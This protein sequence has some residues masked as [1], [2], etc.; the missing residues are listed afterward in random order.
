MASAIRPIAP[1]DVDRVVDMLALAFDD[2]PVVNYLVRQDG[3][4]SERLHRAMR[5]A[6]EQMTLPYGASYVTED[7]AA[8]ALWVPPAGQHRSLLGDLRL[9]SAMLAIGGAA[10][11][12]RLIVA[13]R[14]TEAHAP[15]EAHMHLMTLAVDPALQGQGIGSRLLEDGLERSDRQRLPVYLRSS[16]ERNVPFCERHGFRIT[17]EIRLPRGGPPVWLMWR[18]APA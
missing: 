9:L 2:D 5:V 10:S 12:P 13:S 7:Y 14:L 1:P 4:R 15:H 17:A 18:D 16:K 3:R 8:A 11:I 6:L